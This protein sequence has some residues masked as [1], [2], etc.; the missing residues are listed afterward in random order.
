MTACICRQEAGSCKQPCA[1]AY[2]CTLVFCA[3]TYGHVRGCIPPSQS[4]EPVYPWESL[5]LSPCRRGLRREA[6]WVHRAPELAQ[7][8][9]CWELAGKR[10]WP[11]RGPGRAEVQ[12]EGR[13]LSR[14]PGWQRLI[15]L[16]TRSW[17]WGPGP[18][19]EEGRRGP[20]AAQAR[21]SALG[22]PSALD[23]RQGTGWS[24]SLEGGTRR[25]PR[26]IPRQG[27]RGRKGEGALPLGPGCWG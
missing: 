10:K 26:G 8:R 9:G 17:R 18:L 20:Q 23:R 12:E 7:R 19:R 22:T 25:G 15:P 14:D 16:W 21:D 2:Q 24:C 3:H 13:A 4:W 6:P 5:P 1:F 27:D 11:V